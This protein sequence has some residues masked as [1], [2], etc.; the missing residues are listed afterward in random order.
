MAVLITGG[1]G[2]VGLNVAEELLENGEDVVLFG[3]GSLPE[4]A[5][6]DFS[7]LPG[8]LRAVV[9]DVC[10]SA[11][12]DR[13][14]SE[15]AVERV[16]HG[17]AITAG[18]DRERRDPTGIVQANLMGT[19][20]ILEAAQQHGARRVLY[21][22]SCSVYGESDYDVAKCDEE[23]TLPVPVNLYAISK[24]AAERTALRFGRQW[25]MDVV[26]ARPTEVFGPWERDTGARDTL[27]AP[28]KVTRLA[29]Q[30]R[31]A[32]L[33]RAGQRDWGYSRD[34]ARAI[35]ALL[36]A[37]SPR[38]DVYNVSSGVQWTIAAW[39]DKLAEIYPGF[40]YRLASEDES[41]NVDFYDPR[42]RSP[43]AIERLTQD[44]GFVPE[45]AL[46]ASFKDYM[47]WISG[48]T[49]DVI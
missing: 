30:G 48:H 33:P 13:L 27:S 1:Y 14:M 4:S 7:S 17:A 28:L 40:H 34:V 31:H 41:G 12:L 35:V 15:L 29:L 49:D 5:R 25:D 20:A 43:L 19:I 46:E 42:D 39:C 16:V 24:Y 36:H 47:S 21:L 26:V 38:F 45:F 22:S 6:A 8:T 18:P 2:F 37:D 23:T 11:A 32:V 9:G 10:D 44:I 3:L